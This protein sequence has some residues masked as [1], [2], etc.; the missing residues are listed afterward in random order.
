[1]WQR[2]CILIALFSFVYGQLEDGTLCTP[3]LEYSTPFFDT[4]ENSTDI[5]VIKAF[6]ETVCHLLPEKWERN[7]VILS[8]FVF[9]EFICLFK[10]S[11]VFL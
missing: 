5:I 2:V 6:I 1:M 9:V 8:S 3:C 11:S 10:V 4:F 7:F